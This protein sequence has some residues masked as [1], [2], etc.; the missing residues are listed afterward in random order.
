MPLT[1]DMILAIWLFFLGA[2]IGSFLNVVI[3]RVPAGESIVHGGSHCPKC[4]HAIRWF[5]NI[6]IISWFLLR[7]RCRDCG[8]PIS[9]RYPIIELIVA[10]IF[11]VI[12]WVEPISRGHNLPLTVVRLLKPESSE[13]SLWLL[14]AY[15]MT[16]ITTLIAA[17]VIARDGKRVPISVFMPALVVGLIGA[18]LFPPLHPE[19]IVP[20]SRNLGHWAGLGNAL[21][22]M[23]VGG[24]FGFFPPAMPCR[25]LTASTDRRA[26]IAV[27]GLCGGFLGWR[28]TLIVVTMATILFLASRLGTWMLNTVTRTPWI[29]HA[30]V[31]TIVWVLGWRMLDRYL[32]GG[33]TG[34]EW[35]SLAIVGAT[36]C[37]GTL[38]ARGWASERST[39]AR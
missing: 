12:G 15:Q 32:A 39:V 24:V 29:G 6:P 7:G 10:V 36:W 28:A 2:C 4:R 22:G 3:L 20:G 25:T 34:A 18:G 26:T 13:L 14:Y 5:D 38:M 33:D 8:L 23:L 19:S 30:L 9:S 35:A 37:I 27:S 1:M 17:T 31:A 11:L 21:I 16:L